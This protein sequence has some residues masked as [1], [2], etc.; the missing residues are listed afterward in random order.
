ML[1]FGILAVVKY[2]GFFVSNLNGILNMSGS[3]NTV[4][5]AT[6]A[7]PMGISF[8][9]LQAVD[10]LIDVYR[11]T[12]PAEKNF[13]RLA[14]FVSFFRLL[15]QGPISRY[16]DLSQTLYEEHPFQSR[17]VCLGLQRMLWG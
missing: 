10:Y 16:D 11:E 8:Y 17:N 13:F 2:S 3:E 1:N 6:I 15:V 12:I 5:F 7:L 9:T 14:L 4:S